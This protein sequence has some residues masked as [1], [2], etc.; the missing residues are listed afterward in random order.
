[1]YCLIFVSF[2]YEFILK[3]LPKMFTHI[4]RFY[5]MNFLKNKFENFILGILKCF[6]ECHHI[7]KISKLQKLIIWSVFLSNLCFEILYKS[8][9]TSNAERGNLTFS[10]L[11]FLGCIEFPACNMNF[12]SHSNA[13]IFAFPLLFVL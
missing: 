8:L 2:D 4:L 5:S 12:M 13:A 1:M 11:E 6:N 10:V 3:D 9:C 7:S